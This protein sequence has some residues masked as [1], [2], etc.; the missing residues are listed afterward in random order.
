M[1]NKKVNLLP[2]EVFALDPNL[3][4]VRLD[5]ALCDREAEAHAGG[6]AI[7]ANEVFE[8]FLMMLGRNAG[9]GVFHGDFD[10]VGARQTEATALLRGEW[11]RKRGAPRNAVRRVARRSLRQEC[12]SKRCRADSRRLAG[13]FDSRSGNSE[14][15]DRTTRRA[16]RLCAGTLPAS[17]WKVRRDNRE[18]HFREA[19]KPIC[20]FRA[21]NN[22]RNIETRRTRRSQLSFDSSRMSRCFSDKR[23]REPV[24]KRS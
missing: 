8:N 1:G 9:A 4:A 12:V 18:G 13:L 3:A 7:D 15:T 11:L 6:V 5:K 10:A 23:P 14:S 24:S 17:A 16:E 20:R 21:R 22:S 19:A 2:S